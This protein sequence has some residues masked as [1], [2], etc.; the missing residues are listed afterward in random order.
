MCAHSHHDLFCPCLF[1]E[2]A[3]DEVVDAVSHH[4]RII[5]NRVY[6]EAALLQGVVACVAQIVNCVEQ[7]PVQVKDDVQSVL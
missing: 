1:G 7:C 3:A 2:C 4:T 6:A 5:L